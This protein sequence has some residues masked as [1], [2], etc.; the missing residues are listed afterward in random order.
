[1]PRNCLNEVKKDALR[2]ELKKTLDRKVKRMGPEFPDDTKVTIAIRELT[3]EAKRQLRER[4]RQR[5][6]QFLREREALRRLDLF[7]DDLGRGA[8]SLWAPDKF[9]QR[10][11]TNPQTRGRSLIAESNALTPSMAAVRPRMF[12]WGIGVVRQFNENI[13]KEAKGIRTG[14]ATAARIAREMKAA[15]DHAWKTYKLA[16]GKGGTI[17][18]WFLPPGWRDTELARIGR[19]QWIA[20]GLQHIDRARMVDNETSAQMADD[21]IREL[22]EYAYD[23]ITTRGLNK[24]DDPTKPPNVRRSIA[25][26]RDQSRVLHWTAEGEVFMRQ[27]YGDDDIVNAFLRYRDGLLED[28]AILQVFGTNP[29]KT[30]EVVKNSM[31]H[32][33]QGKRPPVLDDI[34]QFHDIMMGRR[35]VLGSDKSRMIAEADKAARAAT[36]AI[37]LGSA[38]VPSISDF[39]TQLLNAYVR[40]TGVLNRVTEYARFLRNSE[41]GV[42]Q[43]LDDMIVVDT[44]LNADAAMGRF[45]DGALARLTNFS[46]KSATG[47][48]EKSGLTL[49]TDAGRL[50][51][52]NSHRRALG[53]DLDKTWDRLPELRRAQYANYGITP[54][55]W[56]GAIT[57]VAPEQVEYFGRKA[58]ILSFRALREADPDVFRRVH[59]MVLAESEKSVLTTDIRVE[60][61]LEDVPLVGQAAQGSVAGVISGQFKMFKRF[62][63]AAFLAVRE[64]LGNGQVPLGSRMVA[65]SLWM[66]SSI[67]LGAVALQV[68]QVIQGRDPIP[69]LD[70]NG[71][72]NSQFWIMATLYGG[73]LPFVGDTLPEMLGIDLTGTGSFRRRWWELMPTASLFTRTL[74]PMTEAFDQMMEGD[75]EAAMRTLGGEQLAE[76]GRTVAAVFGGNIWYVRGALDHF[77]FQQWEQLVDP[78]GF[79]DKTERQRAYLEGLGQDFFWTPGQALPE[80]A[81]E[82]R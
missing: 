76:L 81:P 7:Q 22:L 25:K 34:D 67:A 19:E 79:A 58:P 14:D 37:L 54:A 3:A 64:T 60:A 78:E 27:K 17:D 55:M 45:D 35:Q 11:E 39:G 28:T 42:Q 57:K 43:A 32:R 18:G 6:I 44:I 13:Q 16:G 63:V 41:A 30:R 40:K 51:A 65:A 69:M 52:L 82:L 77:F 75:T 26:K 62:P 4:K 31:V 53:K 9:G 73:G 48:L 49:H 61:T 24:W 66:A 47:V 10:L 59:E 1:M 50:A 20:D 72:F 70:E 5:T 74:R 68:R 23:S 15:L 21:E 80:R 2:R 29:D 36:T 56:D 71:G 12:R 33:L 8:R 38:V 46:G